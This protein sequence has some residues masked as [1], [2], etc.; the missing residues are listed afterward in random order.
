MNVWVVILQ[1]G[2]DN[3]AT[4]RVAR[5]LNAIWS[6][7]PLL[8]SLLQSMSP[9]AKMQLETWKLWDVDK[10]GCRFDESAH[11]RFIG[12]Q[13]SLSYSYPTSV[14]VLN[15]DKK[16]GK[17]VGKRCL[18]GGNTIAVGFFKRKIG[19]KLGIWVVTNGD[20]RFDKNTRWD[21]TDWDCAL[22]QLWLRCHLALAEGLLQGRGGLGACWSLGGL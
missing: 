9:V 1:F 10:I 21:D 4:V 18:G 12:V 3:V 7:P 20:I 5:L 8:S 11:M 19:G 6:T 13:M 15:S 17:K 14:Q 16:V 22:L 2:S